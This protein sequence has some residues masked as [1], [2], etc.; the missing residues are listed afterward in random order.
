VTD[1]PPR[2]E[3][4]VGTVKPV[5]EVAVAAKLLAVIEE[6]R[7]TAGQPVRAGDVLVVLDDDALVEPT[8]ERLAAYGVDPTAVARAI[9]VSNSVL[10]AGRFTRD[11][12][13]VAVEGGHAILSDRDLA[14]I[15][16]GVHDGRNRPQQPVMQPIRPLR[17]D[18]D[19]LPTG[20]NKTILPSNTLSMVAGFGRRCVAG[21]GAP[22]ATMIGMIALA[23]IVTRDSIIL[24][25]FIELAT[26][27]GRPLLDAILE[28]RV[29][30]LRPIL[31]T[32]G[33]AMLSALPIT[34]DPIFS[35]LGWSLI[36]GLLASTLFTLFVIPVSYRLLRGP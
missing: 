18:P 30:R 1:P 34:L 9:A 4:A 20:S 5:H 19:P 35:G 31:L 26:K 36:F 8:I 13:T 12:R 6:I 27:H 15:V 24:I 23:G 25:D 16:V 10:P 11:D 3:S 14:E 22:N 17:T 28:S 33:T 29:V 7:V 32:A 2:Y 21:F